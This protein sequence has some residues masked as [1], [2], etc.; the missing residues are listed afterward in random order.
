MY[1]LD[2]IGIEQENICHR[3][4]ITVG[5]VFSLT[6]LDSTDSQNNIFS[7]VKF[8]IIGTEIHIARDIERHIARD[9]KTYDQRHRKTYS[10]RHRKT[11]DKRHRKTHSKRHRNTY[12]KR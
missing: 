8:K 11:Y 4:M 9:R 5:L 2:D 10:K 1:G 3:G 6:R 7:L 12:S